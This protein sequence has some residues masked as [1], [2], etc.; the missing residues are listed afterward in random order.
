MIHFY[1]RYETEV[2]LLLIHLCPKCFLQNRSTVWISSIDLIYPNFIVGQYFR[3]MVWIDL[4]D[5]IDPNC[6]L[7]QYFRSTV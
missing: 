3:S 1:P 2:C 4:I 7:G 6:I 5:L